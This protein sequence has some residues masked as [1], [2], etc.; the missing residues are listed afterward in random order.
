M[1]KETKTVSTKGRCA[2]ACSSDLVRETTRK[3][4]GN[5]D[6]LRETIAKAL[7]PEVH[8]G[9]DDDQPLDGEM[10]TAMRAVIDHSHGT[11]ATAGK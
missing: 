1:Y 7:H 10:L 3:R 9:H 5:A 4:V 8:K 2:A 11:N 6:L